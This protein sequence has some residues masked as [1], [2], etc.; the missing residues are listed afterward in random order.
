VRGCRSRP[1]GGQLEPQ[2]T[3][4]KAK[5]KRDS[6]GVVAGDLLKVMIGVEGRSRRSWNQVRCGC[7]ELAR[8]PTAKVTTVPIRTYQVHGTG[9]LKR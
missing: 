2:R 5:D 1:V 7:S 9:V 3:R 6:S 4:R 8:Y